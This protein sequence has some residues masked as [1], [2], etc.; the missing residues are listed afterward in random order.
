[1]QVQAIGRERPDGTITVGNPPR[2]YQ[3]RV[4]FLDDYRDDAN[5]DE[6]ELRFDEVTDPNMGRFFQVLIDA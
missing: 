1:M 3:N 2:E 5:L 4:H 6:F